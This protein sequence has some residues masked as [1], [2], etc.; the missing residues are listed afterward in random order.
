ML[1]DNHGRPL[2]YLR[3]AVTDRCNLRCFYCMPEHGIQF[4]PK[5]E[6]LSFEE[7]ERLVGILVE[8]G[9]SKVRITGGEPFV[10][11]NLM[12][13]LERLSQMEGLQQIN[14][15]SNGTYLAEH[16]PALMDMG[17]HSI[18]LSLDSLDPKRFFE[19][20]RRD[21][22]DTVWSAYEALMKYGMKTK[23]NAVLME[24]HNLDDIIP[25]AA[26]TE[27]DKVAVRFIEEMPFNGGSKG[28]VPIK[29]NARRILEE[30]KG[31]YPTLEKIEDGVSSTS[32]NY[33]V[34][35]FAGTIGVIPAYTRTICGTCDR[36]RMT[37]KGSLKTC[38]YDDGVFNF[39][40]FMR[41]GATDEEIRQQFLKAFGNRAKDGFEAEA[42]K[43]SETS[44]FESM[45]TIGG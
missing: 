37:P 16:V 6:V 13:F 24:E 10:R 19:I 7:M 4:S 31:A 12:D 8:M 9:I 40:D 26:L 41:G 30:V 43:N 27:K 11:K 3:L 34:P 32:H 20:T 28:Y 38:L 25:F 1:Y 22:F 15:T 21:V 5:K 18:N 39:R 36:I 44:S 29:W 2:R 23:I 35:G 14:I 42:R 45:A 17:I 33:Q